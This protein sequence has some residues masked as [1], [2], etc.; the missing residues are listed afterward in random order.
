MR[1]ATWHDALLDKFEV[2]ITAVV[3]ARLQGEPEAVGD[4]VQKTFDTAWAKR[5]KVPDDPL[6]WLYKTAKYHLNNY[7]R[8][9]CR[10]RPELSGHEVLEA[11]IMRHLSN[12]GS[13][14]HGIDLRRALAK[15]T[16]AQC[17]LLMMAYVDEL[18]RAQIAEILGIS[19]AAG[20]Q[21]LQNVRLK[22]RQILGNDY[23]KQ[24][25][26]DERERGR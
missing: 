6:P 11:A 1:D 21:R 12:S 20:R 14:E 15:L 23:L 17:E 9:S 22:I 2:Q 5:Y 4:L 25:H 3:S 24:D 19:S 8:W 13:V 10:R 7:Y 16:P 18:S 26:G